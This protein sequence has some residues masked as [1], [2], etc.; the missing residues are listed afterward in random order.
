MAFTFTEK[1][2]SCCGLHCTGCEFKETH[3]CKGCL[4]TGG[5]PFY[6]ECSIALCCL[7]KGLT[8]CGECEE[9]PCEKLMQWSCDAEQGDS[10]WGAR[11]NQCIR[12]AR[13]AGK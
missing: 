1:V 3:G 8:H 13:G 5:H 6:G 12:W 11:I 9:I 4:E 10:P 7:S 2:D